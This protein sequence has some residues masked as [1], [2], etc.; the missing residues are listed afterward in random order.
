MPESSISRRFFL[1]SIAAGSM[2]VS[3][4]SADPSNRVRIGVMG[5]GGRGRSLAASLSKMTGVEIAA[6]ADP[7]SLRVNQGAG[8][9]EKACGTAPKIVD[10]FRKMLDDK[11]IDAFVCAASN[12]WHAV[13]GIMA[14]N[15]GK[16][17]YIEKPCSHTPQEGEWLV[18]AARKNNRLVQM[19]NQRRTWPAIM[20]AIQLVR[21]GRIGRAYLA[22]SWYRANRPTIGK[23]EK[24]A[25]PKELNYAL[26]EGPSTHKEYQSNFLHYNWHWF[27]HWGNGELG[28]NGVHTID[29]CRW[30]LD[31]SYPIR[32]SSSGGRYRFDDDQ[33][34]PDTHQVSYE[35]EGKKSITWDC[36]SCMQTPE[37]THDI[38]F[39]GDKGSIG[40]R[41]GAYFIYDEKGKQ[42]GTNTGKGG[43]VIHLANWIEAIRGNAKLNSEIEQ[44]HITTLLCHLGNIAH[45]SGRS[46][47]TDSK[48][49]HILNDAEAAKLWTKEYQPG[50]EPKV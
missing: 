20:E 11:S 7:D 8:E 29:I 24:K 35:F 32:V 19:G 38:L 3:L 5:M 26:W 9:V 16:H 30:G 44:G 23:G 4:Q 49:G 6:I 37:T 34:T 2:A 31:V 40:I 18:A 1:G 27:W 48:N 50:F 28:N 13:S 45:R 10:D 43:E 22:Q 36:L 33:E 21:E 39:V 46:L 42:I 12:H 47:K 25:P 17:A 41:G 15:A 14:C